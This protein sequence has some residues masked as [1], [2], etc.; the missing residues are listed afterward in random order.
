MAFEDDME[1]QVGYRAFNL[2]EWNR[3]EDSFNCVKSSGYDL[4]IIT[5]LHECSSSFSHRKQVLNG[6]TV[7]PLLSPK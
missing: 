1:N 7:R 4:N 2:E 6:W 5:T 3:T